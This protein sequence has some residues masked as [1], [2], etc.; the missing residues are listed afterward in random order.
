IGA[1]GARSATAVAGLGLTADSGLSGTL[2]RLG[3]S[4]RATALRLRAGPV[5]AEQ[6]LEMG[7]LNMVV[8]PEQVLAVATELARKLAAGPTAAYACIKES[9]RFG[10]D[11]TLVEAL[12]KEDELQTR[13]GKTADHHGAVRSFLAKTPPVFEGR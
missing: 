13:V 2:P 11:S 5:T 4:G 7:M 6:A 12:A 10:A 9:M 3:G 8:P 1:A